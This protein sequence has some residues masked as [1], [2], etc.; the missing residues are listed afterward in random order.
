MGMFRGGLFEPK[1]GSFASGLSRS[2]GIR[3]SLIVSHLWLR[4]FRVRL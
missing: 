1:S 4:F 3:L 2:V